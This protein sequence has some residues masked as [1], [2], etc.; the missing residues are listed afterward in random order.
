M[1]RQQYER[2]SDKSEAIPERGGDEDT[3]PSGRGSNEGWL[4]QPD[5]TFQYQELSEIKSE[6]KLD[7]PRRGSDE[8]RELPRRGSDKKQEQPGRGSG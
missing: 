8:K 5:E 1:I 4:D 3:E 2:R 6:K 7:L